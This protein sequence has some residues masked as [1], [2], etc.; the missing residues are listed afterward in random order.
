MI[1]SPCTQLIWAG[2]LA[3]EIK[4]LL[5]K[6]AHFCCKVDHVASDCFWSQPQAATSFSCIS[7][8]DWLICLCQKRKSSK[9]NVRSVQKWSQYW[10]SPT[11][12]WLYDTYG[13]PIGFPCIT[14]KKLKWTKWLILVDILGVMPEQL[15]CRAFP[16]SQFKAHNTYSMFMCIWPRSRVNRRICCNLNQFLGT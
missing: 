12:Q 14:H 10:H 9:F 1:W 13:I 2:K 6:Y 8:L 16:V 7:M 5:N 3:T 4:T 11:R 15:R